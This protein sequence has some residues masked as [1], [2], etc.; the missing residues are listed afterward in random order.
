MFA[1]A[2]KHIIVFSNRR[3]RAD[4]NL[5]PLRPAADDND[6]LSIDFLQ[7]FYGV[8]LMHNGQRAEI[9]Q[10]H[11]AFVRADGI[12]AGHLL[13]VP[14]T[15]E[16]LEVLLQSQFKE[17]GVDL[18][19]K[20]Y[21]AATLF[22][23]MQSGGVLYGGKYQ[24]A[25]FQWVNNT[26]DPDDSTYIGPEWIPPQGQNMMYYQSLIVGK[27]QHEAVQTFD[28]RKRKALYDLIQQQIIRD[29]PEYNFV[30]QPDI[31]AANSD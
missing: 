12:E 10:E 7:R 17:V 1:I 31:D 20:N 8:D 4:R 30:W 5:S 15:R 25:I 19:V 3:N 29:V 18:Q 21:P 2:G 22:A 23:P 11:L 16:A 6:A 13:P 14:R 26:P 28:V 24:L 27:A 9:L